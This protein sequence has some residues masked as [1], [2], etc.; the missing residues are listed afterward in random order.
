M[1]LHHVAQGGRVVIPV[2]AG[3]VLKPKT[4]VSILDQ[5]GI[6]PGEFGRLL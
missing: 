4:L 2:H 5:A 3:T 1:I 6:S